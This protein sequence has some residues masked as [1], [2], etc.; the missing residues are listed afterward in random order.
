MVSKLG[1]K[2]LVLPQFLFKGFFREVLPLLETK[3][4]LFKPSPRCY[5][6]EGPLLDSLLVVVLRK[7]REHSFVKFSHGL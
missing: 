3:R 7:S 5:L 6:V 4:H 1:Y 2:G